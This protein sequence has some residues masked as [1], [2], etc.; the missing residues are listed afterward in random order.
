MQTTVTNLNKH[1]TIR[2]NA[3][4]TSNLEEKC[5]NEARP[6]MKGPKRK[7]VLL[8]SDRATEVT[9]NRKTSLS[10]STSIPA[11]EDGSFDVLTSNAFS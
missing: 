6:Q 5:H 2:N 11:S 7:K 1:A 10:S 3:N 9:S 8:V 4:S